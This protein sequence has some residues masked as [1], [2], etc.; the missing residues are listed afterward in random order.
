MSDSSPLFVSALELIAHAT[1]IFAQKNPRKYKF[2]ILHL[3][4][5]IE[6][7]LK[8]FIIDLG[9]SIYKNPKE[10]ITILDCFHRIAER[11]IDIPEK[12]IIELLIDD[13]NVIQHRFGYPDEKTVYYYLVK[14]IDFFQNFLATHY[15]VQLADALK[16]HLSNELMELIGLKK[17]ESNDWAEPVHLDN[18][19]KYYLSFAMVDTFGKI[20]KQI[21][22]LLKNSRNGLSILKIPLVR[23]EEVG[24]QRIFSDL[25]QKGFLP[26]SSY[27]I[28]QELN[29]LRNILAHAPLDA[30]NEIEKGKIEDRLRDAKKLED[31]LHKA[32]NANYKFVLP[33][34]ESEDKP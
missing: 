2:V 32:I 24:S 23:F 10:T 21:K 20:Q 16:L 25:E 13:R 11:N 28:F 17:D 3:A 19:S 33:E 27:M 5:A 15:S 7:I 4:N 9:V 1:E 26:E 18:Q 31:G 22:Q 12:P 30:I 6:L 34:E 8:D 14:V 29:N